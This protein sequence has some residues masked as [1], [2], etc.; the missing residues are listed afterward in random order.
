ML[1]MLLGRREFVT[2]DASDG[3]ALAIC[4]ALHARSVSR[5]PVLS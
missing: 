1:Q 2:P 5:A 4:H 3:L